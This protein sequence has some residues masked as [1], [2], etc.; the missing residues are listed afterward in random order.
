M[1]KMCAMQF[2]PRL[3]EV[4]KCAGVE[5]WISVAGEVREGER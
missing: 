5:H 4:N 3:N 1:K 2:N